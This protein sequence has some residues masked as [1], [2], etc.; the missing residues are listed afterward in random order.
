MSSQSPRGPKKR[1]TARKANP[2]AQMA[3]AEHLR[4]LRNRLIKSA[5]ATVVGMVGG[6]FL[7]I[8][9]MAYIT[10]PLQRLASA[11]GSEAS[12]NYSV[13]LVLGLVLAS[14]V[15]LYQLWAFVTPALHR[16]ER[17][18]AVG[19]LAAAVPLFLSGIAVAVLT[20]P[21]AVYAL[22]AFTPA[23]GTNFISADV[24]LR[25][26]LQ[27]ILT[28]GVAFVL[29]VFLVGLNMLGVLSGRTV[30]KSWRIVVVLVMVVS[31][32][33]APGPDPMTMFYLAVPLLT[34]FFVAV[35]LCLLLDRRRARRHARRAEATGARAG[36]ATPT[37]EIHRLGEDSRLPEYAEKLK[38]LVKTAKRYAT[39]ATENLKETLG[40][41]LADVDWRKLDP[42]QYDP[43]TIVRQALAEDE[44]APP[45][46]DESVRTSLASGVPAPFDAEST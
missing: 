46:P 6:F 9:F 13:S 5:V 15:W 24:Y 36:T 28:F 30:L 27:L 11:E 19:F 42:R 1:R 31:A 33:A 16:T 20:L 23:G 22:T 25:F 37:D 8:P 34:L 41:E 14:P 7:Y 38:Q 26:F 45:R 43:R 39:G 44:P 2:Q 10:E 4:E 40:P 18:Y 35:G 32:M 21:T 12:I 29:P 17:R 3:L